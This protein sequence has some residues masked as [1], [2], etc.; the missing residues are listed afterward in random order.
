MYLVV[1]V[2][3]RLLCGAGEGCAGIRFRCY[4]LFAFLKAQAGF[5]FALCFVVDTLRNELF[6]LGDSG[7]RRLQP[8]RR[9]FRLMDIPL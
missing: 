1:N 6:F 9:L 3:T 7:L 8:F 4:G 2:N 5:A